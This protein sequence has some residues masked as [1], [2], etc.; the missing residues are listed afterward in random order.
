MI[1]VLKIIIIFFYPTWIL[2]WALSSFHW[3]IMSLTAGSL[4]GLDII[5]IAAYT[6]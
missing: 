2:G 1:Y 5:V 4:T 6:D 3:P